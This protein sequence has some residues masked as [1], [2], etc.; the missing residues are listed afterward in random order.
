M[1]DADVE[2]PGQAMLELFEQQT[3]Q[4]HASVLAEPAQSCAR[5]PARGAKPKSPVSPT[6]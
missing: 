6:R 1:E 4:G 3:D 5:I 2:Q